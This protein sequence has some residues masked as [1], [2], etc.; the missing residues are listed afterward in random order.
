VIGGR[1]KLR[2]SNE[3][4]ATTESRDDRDTDRAASFSATVTALR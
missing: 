2:F 3:N 1:A 4:V